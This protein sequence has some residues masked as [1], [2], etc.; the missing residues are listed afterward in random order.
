MDSELVE[1]SEEMEGYLVEYE[2]KR[3]EADNS[4]L[5]NGLPR[6]QNFAADV[7]IFFSNDVPLDENFWKVL[8]SV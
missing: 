6:S 8:A 2:G 3:G 1:I 7:F 4:K 5:T